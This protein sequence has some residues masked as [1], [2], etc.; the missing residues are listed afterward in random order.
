MYQ[1]YSRH[2]GKHGDTLETQVAIDTGHAVY[3]ELTRRLRWLRR[4]IVAGGPEAGTE[5]DH[6]EGRGGN[7]A[8]RCSA[9]FDDDAIVFV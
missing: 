9:A 3:R 2:G 8:S 1:W 7:R 6:N 4:T 5:T